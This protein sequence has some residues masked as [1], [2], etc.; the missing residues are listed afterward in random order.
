MRLQM[1]AA[2]ACLASVGCQSPIMPLVRDPNELRDPIWW[3]IGVGYGIAV[4]TR[5][6][7]ND[8]ADGLYV[9][10]KFYP[11]GAWYAPLKKAESELTELLNR[12]V[13]VA[14]RKFRALDA[15]D[16]ARLR[17]MDVEGAKPLEQ[18]SRLALLGQGDIVLRED[19][20]AVAVRKLALVDKLKVEAEIGSA[21]LSAADAAKAVVGDLIKLA[22]KTEVSEKVSD[23][24]LFELRDKLHW[25]LLRR[26]SAFGGASVGKFSGGGLDSTLWAAGGSLDITPQFSLQLGYAFYDVEDPA[27]MATDTDGGFFAG[28]VFNV[29]SF[30]TL[31][32]RID[33]FT[34]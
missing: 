1:I 2:V 27:T 7:D 33:E 28:I 16:L 15:G 3:D 20:I 21:G 34:K 10:A 6:A 32:G 12:M 4:D 23:L 14:I 25:R 24:Q 26:I 18:I 8:D 11:F 19:Q 22:S 5:S 13:S 17:D 9:S 30:K 29:K 31:L